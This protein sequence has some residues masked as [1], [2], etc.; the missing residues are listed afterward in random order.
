M[1]VGATSQDIV[2]T[3]AMLVS[4][5]ALTRSWLTRARQFRRRLGWLSR[6]GTLRWSGRTLLQQAL[7]T[8]F[9]L[10]AAGWMV[11]LDADDCGA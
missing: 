8:S 10:V 1:H 4:R 5:R 2:D 3:A 6:T 11:A 7:P 9:G